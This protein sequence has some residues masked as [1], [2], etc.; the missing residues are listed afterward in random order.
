[1]VQV[2]CKAMDVHEGR[3]S[4]GLRF[5]DQR[6]QCLPIFFGTNHGRTDCASCTSGDRDS[7]PSVPQGPQAFPRQPHDGQADAAEPGR[8]QGG[9][10]GARCA[11]PVGRRTHGRRHPSFSPSRPTSRTRT[12]LCTAICAVA[13]TSTCTTTSCPCATSSARRCSHGGG[14]QPPP[15]SRRLFQLW[16][17]RTSRCPVPS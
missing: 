16:R 13:I 2:G 12:A 6:I 9:C 4:P 14:R 1:M 17:A 5:I 15:P 7:L 10:S 11:V 8:A 3:T